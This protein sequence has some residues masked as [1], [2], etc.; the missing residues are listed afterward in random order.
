VRYTLPTSRN[1][2][3]SNLEPKPSH[4]LYVNTKPRNYKLQKSVPMIHQILHLSSNSWPSGL[5]NSCS[6]PKN[7]TNILYICSKKQ[8]IDVLLRLTSGAACINYL[9]KPCII[10]RL[11]RGTGA[12][13]VSSLI[14]LW[15]QTR[16][17]NH[18]IGVML[19][20]P[21]SPFGRMKTELLLK[22]SSWSRGPS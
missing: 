5:L 17:G 11:G 4:T 19:R 21:S 10:P 14:G 8:C 20:F 3:S 2:R 12:L 6:K 16:E 18:M 15:P 9:H 22:P 1:Q 13:S 7:T